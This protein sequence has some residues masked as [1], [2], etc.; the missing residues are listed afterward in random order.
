MGLNKDK[1]I[2]SLDSK[3]PPPIIVTGPTAG[4]KSAVA[5]TLATVLNGIIIN[6]DSLQIY[7]GLP[8]LTAQPDLK[9]GR[10]A[11]YSHFEPWDKCDA[12]R[13]LTL[14]QASI[15]SAQQQGKRP[16]IVGGTGF[17]LKVLMEGIAPIP[18][19]PDTIMQQAEHLAN[20]HGVKY[21][22]DDLRQKD[23]SLPN[24]IMPNDTQ[25]VMRAWTVLEATGR[26]IQ[27]WHQLQRPSSAN[28]VKVLVMHE[29]HILYKRINERFKLMWV[30]GILDEVQVFNSKYQHINDN[31]AGKAIGFLE[32]NRYLNGELTDRQAIEAAQTKTRQYA[33]RQLT[34]FRHQFAPDVVLEGE[35]FDV[36]KAL[37]V[38]HK[39]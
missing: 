4:G 32:V 18:T 30:N 21:L 29:R 39:L 35:H 33:K 24:Y 37:M 8:L 10:H 34:W 15:L 25:R 31:Y 26:P 20:V 5:E 23:L 2:H 16:I 12:V 6:A 22:Y 1:C 17:Y 14:A 7:K 27:D 28:F 38:C 11:L 3:K 9:D 36:D 13:W 19:I